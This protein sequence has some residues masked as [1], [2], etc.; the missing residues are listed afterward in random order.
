MHP[1][2]TLIPN[3]TNLANW[4]WADKEFLNWYICEHLKVSYIEN[5]IFDPTFYPVDEWWDY[6]RVDY[7]CLPM[8]WRTGWLR[9]MF[10]LPSKNATM[11]SWATDLKTKEFCKNESGSYL[12]TDPGYVTQQAGI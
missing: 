11:F 9:T 10:V 3:H 6:R 7:K 5:H 12:L 2:G 4:T 8:N 1:L